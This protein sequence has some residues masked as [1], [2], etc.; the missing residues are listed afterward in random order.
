VF[1]GGGLLPAAL[2]SCHSFP[3]ASRFAQQAEVVAAA[4]AVEVHSCS[5]VHAGI[6]TAPVVGADAAEEEAV[7]SSDRATAGEFVGLARLVLEVVEEALGHVALEQAML[8]HF[9][10]LGRIAAILLVVEA[11]VGELGAWAHYAVVA[12]TVPAALLRRRLA[13]LPESRTM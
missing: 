7:V 2:D 13:T 6:G 8:M 1:A 10:H 3:D 5:S 12:L 9:L 11:L 4:N